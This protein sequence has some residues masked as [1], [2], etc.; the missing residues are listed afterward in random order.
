MERQLCRTRHFTDAA[1]I[2]NPNVEQSVIEKEIH[3]KAHIEYW[4]NCGAGCESECSSQGRG[5]S[6]QGMASLLAGHQR[7]SRT[8][9]NCGCRPEDHPLWLR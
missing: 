8:D 2:V 9:R 5:D 1:V 7:R 3:A 4:S 6:L